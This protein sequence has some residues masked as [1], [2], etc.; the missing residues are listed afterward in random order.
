M[1]RIHTPETIR[2]NALECE[3]KAE[4]KTKYNSAYQIASRLGIFEEVCSHMRP[5]IINRTNEEMHKE[6]LQYTNKA[7]FRRNHPNTYTAAHKR[8]IINSICSH[9]PKYV[10]PSGEANPSFKWSVEK[11]VEAALK[12]K[13]RKEFYDRHRGAYAA[14]KLFG[15]LDEICAHMPK[16]VIF[17]GETNPKSKVTDD[18]IKQAAL[19]CK[20]RAEFG[21]KY[22]NVSNTA[23]K[24]GMLEEVCSH[25]VRSTNIS[26]PEHVLFDLIKKNYPKTRRLKDA[27]VNIIGKPYIKGFEID[28]YV[29]ELRKGIEFDGTYWH[30]FKAMRSARSRLAW[31][32]EDI[33][34]YHKIKDKY[35][36][37]K[38]IHILHI[39]EE[40]WE[41]NSQKCIKN[42][43]IF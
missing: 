31:P 40:D 23:S 27:R 9:M 25:M 13:T 12:C 41:K 5:L 21:K 3:T 7:E 37:S 18:E 26:Y 1:K 15:I 2:A 28:I 14:A 32:D 6:A 22:P 17:Y 16:R 10:P 42:A 33:R 4:F 35:F 20:T 36:L 19:K 34:N 24:R 38:G 29:P 11:I 30:S 43:F 39:K 8:G